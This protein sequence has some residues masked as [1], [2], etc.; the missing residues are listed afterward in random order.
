MRIEQVIAGLKIEHS[1]AVGRGDSPLYHRLTAEIKLY[2]AASTIIDNADTD[3]IKLAAD[4]LNGI[5]VG[6]IQ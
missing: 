1:D 2:E 4:N 6:V 5:N 3:T